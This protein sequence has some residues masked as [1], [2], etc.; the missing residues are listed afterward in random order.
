[1]NLR[2]DGAGTLTVELEE[3]AD[4]TR[5]PGYARGR[6]QAIEFEFKAAD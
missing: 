5:M 6:V 1:M 3:L 4:R 2:S